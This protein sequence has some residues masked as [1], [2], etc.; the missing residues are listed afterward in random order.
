LTI[1]FFGIFLPN[2]NPC[3]IFHLM[4][5]KLNVNHTKHVDI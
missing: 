3:N 1:A 5:K 2:V 4:S